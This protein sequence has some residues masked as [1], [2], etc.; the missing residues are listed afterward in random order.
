MRII[1]NLRT[2]FISLSVILSSFGALA[3]NTITVYFIPFEVETYVPVTKN[4]IISQAW[5]KWTISS[6]DQHYQLIKLLDKGNKKEFDEGM[7][8]CLILSDNQTYLIDYN[9]VVIKDGTSGVV[10]DKSKFLQFRKS[11]NSNEI[12]ELKSSI[13]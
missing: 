4:D 11:L 1:L 13:H 10:I 5:E 6:K 12:Q 7:V 3:E 8:R 2:F 9:G